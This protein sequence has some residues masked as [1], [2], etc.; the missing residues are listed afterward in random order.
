MEFGYLN[1]LLS[2][3]V[4]C[5]GVAQRTIWLNIRKT[6]WTVGRHAQMMPTLTSTLDHMIE[7]VASSYSRVSQWRSC[8]R[9]L[10]RQSLMPAFV[11]H[12]KNRKDG[13][14]RQCTPEQYLRRRYYRIDECEHM[15]HSG[16]RCTDTYKLPS[17]KIAVKPT[18]RLHES[19]SLQTMESGSTRIQKSRATLNAEVHT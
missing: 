6:G 8:H 11:T 1:P 7:G 16:E 10:D 3:L 17:R 15:F 5:L 4:R 19:C 13:R 2:T 12:M 9:D 18:L 14:W